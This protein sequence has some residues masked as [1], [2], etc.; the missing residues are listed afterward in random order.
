MITSR[1]VCPLAGKLAPSSLL[2]NIPELIT[3][4]Y[5]RQ[6]DAEI[7]AQRV[8]FGTSGH[9]GSSFETSFNEWHILA[10]T[11]AIVIY[12]KNQAIDGP[13]FMGIDTHALS[14]PAFASALEVLAAHGVEV[15][16]A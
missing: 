7:P 15:M 6:P 12:R 5:C 3:A 1:K 16:I 4:Y 10:I 9:R 8:I 13:L 2:T 11:Q 14:I